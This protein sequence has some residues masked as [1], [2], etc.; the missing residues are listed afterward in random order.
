MSVI[1]PLLVEK[2]RA[3][4]ARGLREER[5]LAWAGVHDGDLAR[6]GSILTMLGWLSEEFLRAAKLN[7]L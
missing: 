2:P 1:L 6:L 7:F 3:A 4:P 5:R